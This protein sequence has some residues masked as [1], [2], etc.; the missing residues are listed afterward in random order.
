VIQL[1]TRQKVTSEVVARARGHLQD[2]ETA[3]PRGL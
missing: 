1:F 3:A 2:P